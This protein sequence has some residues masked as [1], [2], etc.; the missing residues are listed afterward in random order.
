[1]KRFSIATL[2]CGLGMVSSAC[3]DYYPPPPS[4]PPPGV[5]RAHHVR[6]CF[7]HHGGYDPRTNVYIGSDGSPHLC[8][9]PWEK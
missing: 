4:P 1:M 8:V 3:A 2:A 6:W 7:N 9:T 5:V